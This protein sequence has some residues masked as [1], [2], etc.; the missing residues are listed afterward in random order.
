MFDP[1][2]EDQKKGKYD[3]YDSLFTLAKILL[4]FLRKRYK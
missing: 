3:P 1:L 4:Y 2:N